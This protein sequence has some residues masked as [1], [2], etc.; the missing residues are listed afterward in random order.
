MDGAIGF[1]DT[2]K[3]EGCISAHYP[4]DGGLTVKDLPFMALVGALPANG[5]LLSAKLHFSSSRCTSSSPLP[6]ER[7]GKT[8]ESGMFVC[9]SSDFFESAGAPD[10]AAVSALLIPILAD[11]G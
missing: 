4:S 11:N 7:P 9:L 5:A 8:A 1:R 6:C 10:K 3:C 2:V